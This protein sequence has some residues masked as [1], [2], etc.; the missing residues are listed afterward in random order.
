MPEKGNSDQ[1]GSYL[2][3]EAHLL[4]NAETKQADQIE[5]IVKTYSDQKA[6]VFTL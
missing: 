2:Y 4:S 6:L 3:H 1:P 5:T